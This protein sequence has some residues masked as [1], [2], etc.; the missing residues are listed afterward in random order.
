MDDEKR[1]ARSAHRAMLGTRDN[2][3]VPERFWRTA[4]VHTYVGHKI[5]W[6]RRKKEEPL[7]TTFQLHPT[8]R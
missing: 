1:K 6:H 8:P 4:G 5:I 7:F 2:G 3:P